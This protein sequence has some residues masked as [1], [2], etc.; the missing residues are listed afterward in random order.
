MVRPPQVAREH[1]VAALS[2]GELES[3]AL[4]ADALFIGSLQPSP[5]GSGVMAEP[6]A[7]QLAELGVS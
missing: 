6:L 4:D 3:G 1:G 5:E 2:A 7:R